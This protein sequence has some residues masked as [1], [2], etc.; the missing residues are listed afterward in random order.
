MLHCFIRVAEKFQLLFMSAQSDLYDTMFDWSECKEQVT[1]SDPY[2]RQIPLCLTEHS[3]LAI[4]YNPPNRHLL[5]RYAYIYTC[6]GQLSKMRGKASWYIRAM[7]LCCQ[8]CALQRVAASLWV[9]LSLGSRLLP[10]EDSWPLGSRSASTV[11]QGAFPA[12]P[13]GMR[14]L[15]NWAP[16]PEILPLFCMALGKCV[17]FCKKIRTVSLVEKA[18]I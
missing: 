18:I 4:K 8:I 16:V 11:T 1:T 12:L 9:Q 13:R 7:Q 10:A 6:D 2:H 15:A 17:T 5:P 3:S 14:R